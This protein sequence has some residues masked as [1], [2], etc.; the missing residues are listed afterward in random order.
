M[1]VRLTEDQLQRLRARSKQ[2]HISVA[3]LIRRAVDKY[4]EEQIASDPTE[5][6]KR[7][8]RAIGCGNSGLSDVSERHD[9]YLVEAYSE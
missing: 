2:Q 4:L 1:Q 5:L 3:E 6:R 7:A 8:L 9:D